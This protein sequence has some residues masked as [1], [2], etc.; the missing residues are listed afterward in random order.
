M[1]ENPEE[2]QADVWILQSRE[3]IWFYRNSNTKSCVFHS[4]CGSHIFGLSSKLSEVRHKLRLCQQT[5]TTSQSEAVWL[6]HSGSSNHCS[7]VLLL[8]TNSRPTLE[9]FNS[10]FTMWSNLSLFLKYTRQKGTSDICCLWIPICLCILFQ[11]IFSHV[12]NTSE[13]LRMSPLLTP[14]SPFMSNW[15]KTGC[16]DL[17]TASTF[18]NV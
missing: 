6:T 7:F 5:Y 9:Q 13:V 16:T 11:C 1:R 12:R 4:G 8:T 18:H 3:Q 15:L 2:Q 14:L 17:L 10:A